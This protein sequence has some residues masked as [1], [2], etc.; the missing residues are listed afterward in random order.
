VLTRAYPHWD[1]TGG[2][3]RPEFYVRKMIESVMHKIRSARAGGGQIQLWNHMRP[4]QEV[5]GR[6]TPAR[7]G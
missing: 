7:T 5:Y 2:L 3:D 4:S 1:R 6:V